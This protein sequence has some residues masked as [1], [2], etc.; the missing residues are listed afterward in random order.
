[1]KVYILSTYEE[2]GANHVTATTDPDELPSMVD[3]YRGE[4]G[5]DPAHELEMLRRLEERG[6]PIEA[7]GYELSDGWGGLQIHIVELT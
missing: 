2:Y 3:A 5:H 4:L 7:N 6:Y 1:M